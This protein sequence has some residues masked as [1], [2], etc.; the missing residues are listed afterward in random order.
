LEQFF[1]ELDVRHRHSLRISVAS[2][3]SM[4]S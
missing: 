2:S 3:V 4:R 1:R